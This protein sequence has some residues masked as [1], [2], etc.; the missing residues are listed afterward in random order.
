MQSVSETKALRMPEII[1]CILNQADICTLMTAQL[2]CHMWKDLIDET[3]SLQQALFFLPSSIPSN[4]AERTLNP[5]LAETFHSFFPR[6]MPQADPAEVLV[7]DLQA[8]DLVKESKKEAYFR[9]EAS[10][11]RML[12]HQPPMRNIGYFEDATTPFGWGWGQSRTFVENGLRMG[13]LL[14]TVIDRSR[15]KLNHGWF[16]VFLGGLEPVNLDPFWLKPGPNR[17]TLEG[18][19]VAYGEMVEFELV[20]HAGSGSTCV[21]PDEDDEEYYKTENEI[22][23]EEIRKEYERAGMVISGLNMEKYKEGSEMWD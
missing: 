19:K 18:P 4:C 8:L 14:D 3:P 22:A 6:K 12:T 1:T 2:V 16:S 10:W 11:R 23:W 13:P 20:I 5:L 9:P 21:D 17:S 7:I 15:W